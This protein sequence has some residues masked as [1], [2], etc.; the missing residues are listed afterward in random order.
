MTDMR[1]LQEIAIQDYDNL[2][3][4]DEEDGQYGCRP[5]QLIGECLEIEE[6][7]QEG[8]AFA[9]SKM[10]LLL[11]VNLLEKLLEKIKEVVDQKNDIVGI[12]KDE[13]KNLEATIESL[14]I[15]KKEARKNKDFNKYM[16]VDIQLEDIRDE[17]DKKKIELK[18]EEVKS[19][20]SV[21]KTYIIGDKSFQWGGKGARSTEM[22]AALQ[23]EGFNT[24][25]KATLKEKEAIREYLRKCIKD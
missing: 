13:I 8:L 25:T 4:T 5:S 23:K 9:I 12:L 17:L 20:T 7:T 11:P 6:L 15:E 21:K 18:E 10:V 3:M 22:N 24:D 19:E 2:I 16:E 14:K 1:S